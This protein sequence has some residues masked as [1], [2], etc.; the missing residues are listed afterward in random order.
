[1]LNRRHRGFTLVEL[2]VVLAII[3]ILLILGT[4]LFSTFV[5]NSRIRTAAEVFANAL[6]QARIEAIKRN[7]PVEFLMSSGWLVCTVADSAAGNCAQGNAAVLFQGAG[8]EGTSEVT[9]TATPSGATRI[10]FDQLGNIIAVSPIDSS[11][12]LTQVDIDVPGGSSV[13]STP[14]RV[15]IETGGGVHLCNPA[16]SSPNP[17]ACV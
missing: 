1:M 6:S 3:A 5:A 11:A 10:T 17:E 4:P 8:K 12:A 7:E 15:L 14:L 16:V 13:N 2:M 9:V